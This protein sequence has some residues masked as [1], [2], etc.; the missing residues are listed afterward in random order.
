MF[1]LKQKQLL[2]EIETLKKENVAL[3][4]QIKENRKLSKQWENFLSYDG[5]RQGDTL[6]EN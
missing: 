6:D 4:H 5:T 2:N 3:R 1:F